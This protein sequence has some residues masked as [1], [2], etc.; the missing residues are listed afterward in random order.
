MSETY[1]DSSDAP[2]D[3]NLEISGY[4]LA[5]SDHPAN[6]KRGEV[7]VYYKNFLPLGVFGIQY[8][9]E[10]INFELKLGDKFCNIVALFRSP[11]QTQDEY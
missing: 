1:L 10:C 5:R 4:N 7:C 6:N 9:H 2:D 8:L 11:R 3:G